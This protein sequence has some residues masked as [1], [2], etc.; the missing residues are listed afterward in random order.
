MAD[1]KVLRPETKLGDDQAELVHGLR[2][3]I[4]RA[5]AGEVTGIVAVTMSGDDAE[6]VML[7]VYNPWHM[8]GHLSRTAHIINL[9]IDSVEL[10]DE[11][12]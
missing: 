7:G 12:E 8:L 1:V 11:G 4:D 2:G 6:M 9:G 10:D 3:L 5:L